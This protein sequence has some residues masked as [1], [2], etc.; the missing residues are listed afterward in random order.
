MKNGIS[1]LPY[2][3][4][5]EPN[6][7]CVHIGGWNIKFREYRTDR[8][9]HFLLCSVQ[10]LILMCNRSYAAV[11]LVSLVSRSSQP[12]NEVATSFIWDAES[13]LQLII[14]WIS[15]IKKHIGQNFV[16]LMDDRLSQIKSITPELYHQKRV[17]PGNKEKFHE[18]FDAFPY[19]I[20]VEWS[21]IQGSNDEKVKVLLIIIWCGTYSF[22]NLIFL[23]YLRLWLTIN[24]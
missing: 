8:K 20:A 1:Y 15:I 12:G 10:V 4:E 19:S 21:V 23:E 9:F 13:Y 11:D 5:D 17:R 7:I 18:L 2:P 24:L 22:L 6:V 16:Q 3:I 14:P